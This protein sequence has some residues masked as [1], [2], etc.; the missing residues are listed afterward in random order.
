MLS[1]QNVLND[2]GPIKGL[3][4]PGQSVQVVNSFKYLGTYI[5]DKINLMVNADSI[6]K[7][8]NQRSGC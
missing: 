1:K 3:S 5:D 6:Y 8:A 2:P 7:K 4:L